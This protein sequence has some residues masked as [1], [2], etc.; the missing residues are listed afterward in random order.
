MSYAKSN[1]QSNSQSNSQSN[2]DILTKQLVGSIYTH[3]DLSKF[4]YEL[5]QYE[6]ELNKLLKCRYYVSLNFCGTNCLLVFTKIRDSFYCFT[7]DRQTLS[8]NFSKVDFSKI[9]ISQRSVALDDSIY[10][11]TIF[12]GIL[13]KRHNKED[14]YVISD[15]YKFCGE[16]MLKEQID[17]KLYKI[18]EYLNH[19]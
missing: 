5:L 3:V 15:V 16:N 18:R 12:D 13:I 14:L 19:N 2:P 4:R 9:N 17:I 6:S 10:N 1:L 11:G 8:Y 7:V